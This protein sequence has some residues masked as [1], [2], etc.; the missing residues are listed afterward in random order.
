MSKTNE[1]KYI[2]IRNAWQSNNLECSLKTF[3]N[4]IRKSG[5]TVDEAVYHFLYEYKPRVKRDKLLTKEWKDSGLN[6]TYDYFK[7]YIRRNPEL[8]IEQAINNMRKPKEK[9]LKDI[10][11]EAELNNICSYGSFKS[12]KLNHPELT[13]EQIINH[14]KIDYKPLSKVN[15]SVSLKK[16]YSDSGLTCS[17]EVF[18]SYVYQYKD[19]T[20][21]EIIEYLKTN[22]KTMEN[23]QET[24]LSKVWRDAK[25][26]CNINYFIRYVKKHPEKT[27]QECI[28]HFK[29][30]AYINIFGELVIPD[31]NTSTKE[32]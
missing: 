3:Q 5:E 20:V 28:I 26:N 27:I 25:L 30:D 7:Y 6:C 10:Y 22:Y 32:V 16:I 24:S 8:S 11:L 14:Y 9:T 19:K 23:V 29:P 18:K 1:Q 2:E 13:I 12:Y 4:Y 17:Y 15:R 31:T 21:E